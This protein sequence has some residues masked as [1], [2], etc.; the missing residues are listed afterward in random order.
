MAYLKVNFFAP[1]LI[2]TVDVDILIPADP[3]FQFGPP[4]PVKYKT[5]YLLHGF[6]GSHV[7]WVV[8]TALDELSSQL[9]MAIVMPSGE[10]SFYVDMA[11]QTM[12]Y[13]KFIGEDLVSFTRK[14][15]PLSDKREDT[16]IAGLSMGGYG[17]LYNGLKYYKTFG[18]VIGLSSA[19]VYG[20]A[21]HATDEI[22]PMGIN[23][24]YFEQIFGDLE[25]I[26]ASEKNLERLAERVKDDAEKDGTPLDI[27]FACGYND[28]LVFGNRELHKH[29]DEIGLK[30]EYREGPGTHDFE[31]WEEWLNTALDRLYPLPK[32]PK[33]MMPFWMEKP[34]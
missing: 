7:D 12:R 23:R 24:V 19:L 34:E 8:K 14:L 29:M 9:N 18:H 16:L 5:L 1:S 22:N 10:N 13:S 11:P 4:Q 3:Q 30:H 15:L 17:A 26:D 20:E 31:F 21:K 28:S 6:M 25:K 27:F 33:N 32:I 2:R